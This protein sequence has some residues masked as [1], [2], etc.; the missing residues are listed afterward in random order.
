MSRYID[1]TLTA[2]PSMRGIDWETA[3]TVEEHGWNARLLHFYS[4]SG[5]HMDSP[6]HFNCGEQTIDEIPLTDCIITARVVDLTHLEPSALIEVADLGEIPEQWTPG[7]SLLLHTGWSAHVDNAD[8]YRSSF[9]RISEGL[10]Q[11][12]V[13]RKMCVLVVWPPSDADVF[14]IEEVTTIHTILLTGNVVIVEGLTHLDQ[15]SERKVTFIALPL[16]IEAGDGAPC[17][18]MAIENGALYHNA[19]SPQ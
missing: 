12:C 17:R 10:A 19:P 15:L 1:L 9:P 2:R 6:K 11:W 4:R 8:Y 18:A 7:E 5:S 3:A 16:K 13:E 14:N